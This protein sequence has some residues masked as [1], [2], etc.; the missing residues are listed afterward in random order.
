MSGPSKGTLAL[1]WSRARFACERCGVPLPPGAWTSVHHRRAKGMGGD[2]RPG[3]HEPA[4]LVLLCGSGTTGCH[5]H[6][7][8][9]PAEGRDEG[10]IVSRWAE[11]AEVGFLSP[12]G[13]LLI[14]N[15]GGARQW[16]PEERG[17]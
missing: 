5:G 10:F 16:L 7:H 2:R 15:A 4:N 13:W 6:V 9:N 8:A 3:T 12:R 14:D 1:V 11:P 17:R